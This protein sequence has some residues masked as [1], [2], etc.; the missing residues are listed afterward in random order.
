MQI[1]RRADNPFDVVEDGNDDWLVEKI[2]RDVFPNADAILSE[3]D[4][5][6]RKK[7]MRK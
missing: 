3:K 6:N 5:K 7:K 4:K 1:I 2:V